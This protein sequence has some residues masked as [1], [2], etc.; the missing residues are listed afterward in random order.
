MDEV[1]RCFIYTLQR[2]LQGMENDAGD[3]KFVLVLVLSG[4][5]K[6]FDLPLI[7]RIAPVFQDN[8]PER[9]HKALIYP[10]TTLA[11]TLWGMVQ[12]FLNPVTRAKI[13]V[14]PQRK[15]EAQRR[16][17][18]ARYI[19]GDQLIGELGGANGTA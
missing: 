8:F 13:S 18:F 11:Q 19:P 14:V 7:R 2:A 9:L 10:G 3:G 12:Y 4:P 1:I 15:D 16:E 17:E 5:P 6:Q